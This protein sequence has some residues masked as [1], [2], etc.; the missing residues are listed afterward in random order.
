MSH[1]DNYND[2]L[3]IDVDDDISRAPFYDIL[4]ITSLFHTRQKKPS[5]AWRTGVDWTGVNGVGNWFPYKEGKAGT[6]S[7]RQ[8][9]MEWT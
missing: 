8:A 5:S 2:H 1:F 7:D 6:G 4:V 3:H 9:A